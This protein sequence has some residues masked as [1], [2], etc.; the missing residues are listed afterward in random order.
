[1]R[2]LLEKYKEMYVY[3]GSFPNFI[4]RMWR[5][6]LEHINA[7]LYD[8]GL[9]FVY[10]LV[11]VKSKMHTLKKQYQKEKEKKCEPETGM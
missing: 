3:D 7:R 4:M 11:Q 1:M 10:T 2:D 9:S 8:C 5:S 6:I